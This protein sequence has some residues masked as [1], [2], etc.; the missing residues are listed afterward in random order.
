MRKIAAFLCTLG[1]IGVALWVGLIQVSGAWYDAAAPTLLDIELAMVWVGAVSQSLF[2]LLWMTQP[3]WSTGWITRA[4]MAKSFGLALLL[5][6]SLVNY[7]VPAYHAAPMV[8]VIVVGVVVA[9][10]VAQLC[11]LA[12]DTWRG[13]TAS[14]E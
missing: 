11:A 4:I 10:S 12:W 1:V 7:Y 6:I 3:W 13:H 9:G 8:A 14:G 2:V 5:D